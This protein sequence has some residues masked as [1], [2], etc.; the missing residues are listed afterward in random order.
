MFKNIIVKDENDTK[1]S[2]FLFKTM[3]VCFAV[4]MI[5]LI[6]V[7]FDSDRATKYFFNGAICY[8]FLGYI[9]NILIIKNRD[10]Q[11]KL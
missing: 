3:Y 4:S 8:L 9:R 11:Q 10:K 7:F 6:F 1:F 2:F 5:S